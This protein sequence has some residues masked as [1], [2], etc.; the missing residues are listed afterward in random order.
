MTFLSRDQQTAVGV[1]KA[2]LSQRGRAGMELLGNIQDYSSGFVRSLA[3]AHF[4]SHSEVGKIEAAGPPA[5]LHADRQRVARSRR[6]AEQIPSYRYERFLQRYVAEEV[7]YRGIPAVEERRR[8]FEDLAIETKNHKPLGKNLL[9][10][11]LKVPDY[12]AGVDWHLEPGGYDGY[13]LY[14]HLFTHVAGPLVFSY[15]GYAA[16]PHREDITSHRVSVVRQFR[17]SDLRRVYEPGCGGFST[18]AAVNKVF[19]EAT[20][21]GSDISALQLTNGHLQAE[22]LGVPVTFKQVDARRTGEPDQSF[23]S[24]ILYALLHEMP[25]KVGVQ[26]LREMFRILESGGEIVISDPPPFRAVEPFQA[27]VLDWDTKNRGE[28]YFSAAGHT[29]WAEE[30]RN[31]GFKDV[32]EYAIGADF[33]PWVTRG[34]KPV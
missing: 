13:E 2:T 28:P 17:R 18:L 34:R 30:L 26:I 5:T 3:R 31:I 10:P 19:P 25:P 23:D 27:V 6:I 15:G 14:G 20:L 1:G 16:V 21:V 24:A 7:Y 4:R 22:R 32:E 12:Y 11:Q 33:Y 8:E 29:N 9:D